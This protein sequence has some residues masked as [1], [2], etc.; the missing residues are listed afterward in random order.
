MCRNLKGVSTQSEKLDSPFGWPAMNF[1]YQPWLETKMEALLSRYPNVTLLRGR[2]VT[3]FD[4]DETGVTVYHNS[5]GGGGEDS[6]RADWVVGC[7]GGRSETRK[8][9]NISMS[10]S[11]FPE[12]WLVLDLKVENSKDTLPSSALLQLRL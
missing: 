8:N 7:D 9:L 2:E 1:L 11:R 12:R 6:V 3:N 10:G 4:Q 5:T